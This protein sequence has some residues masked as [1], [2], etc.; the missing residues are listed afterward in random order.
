MEHQVNNGK[1][2]FTRNSFAN[3]FGSEKQAMALLEPFFTSF[4][5]SKDRLEDVQTI[6]S[7]A[8][9]NAIEH[10]NE[11]DDTKSYELELYYDEGLFVIRVY[12]HGGASNW[13]GAPDFPDI[14]GLLQSEKEPR[15][16]GLKIIDSLA[17]RWEFR[18]DS[19]CTC[20]EIEVQIERIERSA[21]DGIRC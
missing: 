21:G 1:P 2:Y 15:G 17:D 18:I 12:D 11:L 8:C 6:V 20:L 13:K 5:L 9:L 16:W 3:C 14:A 4:N 10:G 19:D 7:E